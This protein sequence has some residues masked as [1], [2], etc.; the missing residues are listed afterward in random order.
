MA[1]SGAKPPKKKPRR[2]GLFIPAEAPLLRAGTDHFDL[3]ATVLRAAFG[4]LVVGDRLLL[5]L[6]FG[7]DPVLLDALARQVRLDGF[8]TTDRQVLVVRIGSPTES[9]WP[10]AMMT[11]RF[12]R[13]SC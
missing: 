13:S 1:R 9:V 4:G 6:A 7:V 3:H 12:R 11:S 5:A 10:T 8:G 2:A